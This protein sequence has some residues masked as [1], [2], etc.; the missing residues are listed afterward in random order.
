LNNTVAAYVKVLLQYLSIEKQEQ[1][2]KTLVWTASNPANI[3]TEYKSV[4]PLHKSASTS[5]GI[6]SQATAVI[7]CF[8]F[9]W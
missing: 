7:L 9:G 5:H 3:Q 8:C 4:L 1:H 6:W 2:Q